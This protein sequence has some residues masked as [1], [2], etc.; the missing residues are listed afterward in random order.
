MKMELCT[1]ILALPIMEKLWSQI[2]VLYS[3]YWVQTGV[4]GLFEG[5]KSS[6][7]VWERLISSRDL[8][9][10]EISGRSC[11]GQGCVEGFESF[12]KN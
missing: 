5:M 11:N 8:G 7:E 10:A 2:L 3:Q 4:K 9:T 6:L 12:F 1:Q